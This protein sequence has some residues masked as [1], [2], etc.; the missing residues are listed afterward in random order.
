MLWGRSRGERHG[1]ADIGVLDLSWAGERAG[2]FFPPP[3]GGTTA[4]S[5]PPMMAASETRAA[6]LTASSPALTGR[7]GL[8]AGDG[9]GGVEAGVE[10]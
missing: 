7:D 5:T 8:D 10:S 6:I 2:Y 3:I 4:L 1:S 9:R